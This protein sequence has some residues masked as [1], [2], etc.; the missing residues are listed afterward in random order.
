MPT[1][2]QI[3]DHLD[4]SQAEVS[5]HMERLG[6]DW[7]AVSMDEIR[8]AYLRHLRSVAAGHRSNDGLD[9]T[10]ERVLTERV[11]RELKLLTVAEKKGMLVNVQQLESELMNMIAA[12]RTELISRDDALK[13]ELDALYGIDVD[14]SLLNERTRGILDQLSRYDAGHRGIAE[15]ADAGLAAA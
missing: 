1:Q 9:L 5:H 14:L 4:L 8:V 3:A 2:Q 11:D 6:I 7:K 10:R 15:T 13:S 12:F